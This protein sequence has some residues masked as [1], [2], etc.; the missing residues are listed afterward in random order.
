[1]III[2]SNNLLVFLMD[3][4]GLKA[5]QVDA[6]ILLMGKV[7]TLIIG[8]FVAVIS[9]LLFVSVDALI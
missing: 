2:Q 4:L 6:W 3:Q 5:F 8:I 7:I 9:G 1:M